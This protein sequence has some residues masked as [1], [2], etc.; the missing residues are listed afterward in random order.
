MQPRSTAQNALYIY[1][2]KTSIAG[3]ALYNFAGTENAPMQYRTYRVVSGLLHSTISMHKVT[4]ISFNSAGWRHPTGE[5]RNHESQGTYSHQNGF[6]HE[7]WLFRSEWQ[8]DGWRYSF[9]QGVN[10][11]RAKL[12]KN[13]ESADITLFTI[14]PDKRRRYIATIRDVEFLDDVHAEDALDVFEE[15][16]WLDIMKAEIRNVGGNDSALGDIQWAR[17]ILNVRFRL[18]NV[19]PFKSDAF[20]EPTDSIM[21]WH[22]YQLHEVSEDGLAR[23]YDARIPRRRMGQENAPI[24]KPFVRRAVKSVECSPEHA[25]MQARLRAELYIEYPN[26]R[27][28]CEENYV[29]VKVETETECIFFEIKSDISPRA[30]MRQALGQLL[31]YAFYPDYDRTCPTRLVVVGRTALTPTDRQYLETLRSDFSLPLEYRVV[32][33]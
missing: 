10:K 21:Q 6:G 13:R 8:I 9:L 1:G 29:D 19:I 7:D 20:A 33:I 31:E 5:A 4:R 2:S 17:H 32:Q 27:I 14:Q 3:Q 12:I 11:S 16:G 28:V 26:A 15:R 23:D 22:R 24:A 25:K 18:V 30:V